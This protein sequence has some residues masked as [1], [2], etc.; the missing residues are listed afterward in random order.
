MI[1]KNGPF[2]SI[3]AEN[4]KGV[5]FSYYEIGKI[6]AS[7]SKEEAEQKA[8]EIFADLAGKGINTVFFHVRAF[9]DAFYPSKLFPRSEYAPK[10][11]DLLKLIIEAAHAQQ[12]SLHAWINPYRVANDKELSDLPDTSPAVELYKKSR[13]NLF[14]HKGGIY[15]NPA[16]K[17]VQKLILGG[18]RELVESYDID[19]IHFDDYFYQKNSIKRVMPLTKAAAARLAG[20][21]TAARMSVR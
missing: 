7:L 16:R 3:S 10:S 12:I 11:F 17:G 5:W 14:F 8:E 18:I 15:M 4:L 13:Q 19:G 9:A 20:K 1:S 6:F 21:I 2:T